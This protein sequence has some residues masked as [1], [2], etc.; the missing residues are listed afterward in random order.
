MAQGMGVLN[1]AVLCLIGLVV[2][3]LVGPAF[4][5]EE[6]PV[7]RA[8]GGVYTFSTFGEPP[9]TAVL[10]AW[11]ATAEEPQE[12]QF[13]LQG[14]PG[15]NGGKLHSW[16]L[17][18]SRPGLY[19][20]KEDIRTIPAVPGTYSLSA[21]VDGNQVRARFSL[22]AGPAMATPALEVAVD[23][24]KV[25]RVTWSPVAEARSYEVGFTDLEGK[26]L[27]QAFSRGKAHAFVVNLA[28]GR[29]RARVA[30]YTFDFTQRV[31]ESLAIP[32]QF[33]GVEGTVE[34][35]MP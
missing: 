21:D 20:W 31:T 19:V 24:Q 14:P 23:E 5:T 30:A 16:K 15:W 1:R 2:I 26:P 11:R 8:A 32:Q 9:G 25:I 34:F 6:I 7:L 4:A 29:Y 35:T 27:I 10:Y 22:A 13:T 33:H 18:R 28:P 3:P 12:I 17:K